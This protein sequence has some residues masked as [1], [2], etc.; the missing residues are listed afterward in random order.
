MMSLPVRRYLALLLTAVLVMSAG[1]FH[2]AFDSGVGAGVF[3][4]PTQELSREYALSCPDENGAC[5]SAM[6][7]GLM[8][9]D[10]S[11]TSCAVLWPSRDLISAV[12]NVRRLT[13]RLGHSSVHGSQLSP[14]DRPP[15]LT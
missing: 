3:A 2:G 8:P 9:S 1:M 11:A 10:C 14:L 13:F 7:P 4:S 15:L 5:G 6:N 12:R